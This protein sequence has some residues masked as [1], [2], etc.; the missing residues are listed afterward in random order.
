MFADA[1]TVGL[2][3]QDFDRYG[4]TLLQRLGD[5][6][7][8]DVYWTNVVLDAASGADTVVFISG[9]GDGG[10]ASYWGFDA[11]DEVV[12]LVTDFG[13]LEGATRV[14]SL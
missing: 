11:D 4:D 13:V 7:K 10:Y 5:V 8:R 6:L 14:M 3:R 12:C 9:Y 2:A 1:Q